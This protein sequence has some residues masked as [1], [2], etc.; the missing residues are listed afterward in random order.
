MPPTGIRTCIKPYKL[1]LD[2]SVLPEDQRNYISLLVKPGKFTFHSPLA[3]GESG[4][5]HVVR[6]RK[7]HVASGYDMFDF[8]LRGNP[9]GGDVEGAEEIVMAN[10]VGWDHAGRLLV[11][12]GRYSGSMT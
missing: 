7:P 1:V 8:V 2:T 3:R 12:A 5:P 6:H 4:L 9:D 10:W 11:A